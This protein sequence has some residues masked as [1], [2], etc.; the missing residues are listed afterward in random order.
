MQ[1]EEKNVIERDVDIHFS[2]FYFFSLH[3]ISN[4]PASKYDKSERIFFLLRN[5]HNKFNT[6]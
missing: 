6:E 5:N 1:E 3:F 4:T 2:W